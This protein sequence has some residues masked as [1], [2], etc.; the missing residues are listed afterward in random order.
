M[1]YDSRPPADFHLADDPFAVFEAWLEDAREAEINDPTAM[2]LATVD[3]EGLPDARMVL[4]NGYDRRG[5]V[6]YTNLGS[7]KARELAAA[8]R[9][10]AVFHWKSLRRQVRFRG[11]VE[12]VT[13]EEADAYYATRPRLSRIGAWASIQSQPLGSRA[14]LEAAVAAREAEFEGREPPR[15]AWWSGFRIVPTAIEFWLDM[16]YRL[17]DRATFSRDGERGAWTRTRLY[18]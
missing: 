3:A 4:M 15:P 8:P 1:P 10:A 2:A 12:A 16:P 7:A 9:A 11:P 13:A 17:H 18:P 6:F 5:L 14:E